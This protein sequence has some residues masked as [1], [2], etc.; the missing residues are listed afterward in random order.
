M[1]VRGRLPG[2][3]GGDARAS[4]PGEGGLVGERLHELT[5]T[6]LGS[7]GSHIVAVFLFLA[8]VL[9]L[10]GASVAS[11]LKAT[12]DSVTHAGRRVR[13]GAEPVRTAV[14]RIR[15]PREELA[16]LEA[17]KVSAVTRAKQ[18]VLVG[19][20]PVPGPVRGRAGG[21]DGRRG[22]T[23]VTEPFEPVDEPGSRPGGGGPGEP[24]AEPRLA[25]D[26]ETDEPGVTRS[27]QATSSPRT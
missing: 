3:R 17:S 18:R 6:L 24:D 12:G 11:V 7:V 2:A 1:P 9:L 13:Q 23:R 22:R 15:T 19:R 27:T 21:A 14:T 25:E 5:S 20:R 8:G 26:P 16:E 10:T 4:G